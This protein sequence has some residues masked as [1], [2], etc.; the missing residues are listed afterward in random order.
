[1]KVLFVLLGTMV[2][3]TLSAKTITPSNPVSLLP[4]AEFLFKEIKTL[5]SDDDK[6]T[7]FLQ[8]GIYYD[9]V[10]KN[11]TPGKGISNKEFLLEVYPTDMNGDGKEEIFIG[12]TMGANANQKHFF[13]VFIPKKGKYQFAG[14]IEIPA[15]AYYLFV[16]KTTNGGYNDI[17][18]NTPPKIYRFNGT[19]YKES[20]LKPGDYINVISDYSQNYTSPIKSTTATSVIADYVFRNIKSKLTEEEKKFFTKEV[21]LQFR[22][23]VDTSMKYN[24]EG[25]GPTDELPIASLDIFPVDLNK[26]GVEEV[27]MRLNTSYFGQWLSPLNLFIK[28]KNGQFM[29][30]DSMNEPRLFVRSTGNGGFPDLIG[31]APEGPG[32]YKV[33]TKFNVYR[34]NGKSYQLYKRDQPYLK[35]DLSIEEKIGPAYQASLPNSLL[36]KNLADQPETKTTQE[37]ATSIS[38]EGSSKT[39]EI[40][41]VAAALFSG[42]KTKL[43][44]DQKNEV[45]YLSGIK[46]EEINAKTIN[47][48]PKFRFDIYPLDLNKNGTEEIFFCITTKTLGIPMHT[49]SFYTLNNAGHFQPSPGVIGQGVKLILNRVGDFPDLITG[50]TL[51]DRQVWRWNGQA[52][53]LAQTIK[54][55]IAINYPTKS[56][57]D[58]SKEYSDSQ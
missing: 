21:I 43:S 19:E 13:Q 37:P 22:N 45:A 55:G 33:P 24:Y 56:I 54:S 36:Q 27:F 30:Q 51:S 31:A 5:L 10:K 23:G 7:I 4:G 25:A 58:A 3:N 14:K 2:M 6:N 34:W 50:S 12:E 32:F 15:S 16:Y 57:E 26:D 11:L 44:V 9:P 46:L 49:Y 28:N 41:P 52:Y 8:T 20:G 42:A 53:R 39:T 40:T 29:Q 17:G 48:K 18:F 38:K 35:S 1:M 47:G